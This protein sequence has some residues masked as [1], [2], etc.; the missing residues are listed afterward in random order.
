[1]EVD[2]AEADAPFVARGSRFRER[3]AACCCECFQASAPCPHHAERPLQLVLVGMNPSRASWEQGFAYANPSNMLW[4][5]LTG[6]PLGVN[7]GS[8]AFAGVLPAGLAL[9][10]QN[11]LPATHGVGFTD[12][13]L[14]PESDAAA[15]S[16]AETRAMVPDLLRRLRAHARRAGRAPLLVAF[17]GV[18][19]FRAVFA[20]QLPAKGAVPLGEWLG[21]R[22]PGWPFGAATRVWVLPSSSGRAVLSHEQRARPY[23]ELAQAFHALT[24]EKTD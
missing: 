14:V 4:Q 5:L 20:G 16:D 24:P 11:E 15:F 19:Q 12:L 21:E 9:A 7:Q 3:L 17:T 22:P 10:A 18:K 13:G 6:G 1:V 2:A 23:R 8:A